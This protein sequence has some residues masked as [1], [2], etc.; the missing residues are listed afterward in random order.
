MREIQCYPAVTIKKFCGSGKKIVVPNQSLSLRQIVQR[1]VRRESLPLHKPG[2]Y[3]ERFGDL[4]KLS[5][6]DITVRM[7]KVEELKAQIAAFEKREKDRAEKAAVDKL[8]K[9]QQDFKAAVLAEAAK[10]STPAGVTPV[11]SPGP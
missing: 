9:E 5:T 10:S 8:A 7:D 11:K 1:F 3:E 6:A 4:E 2:I